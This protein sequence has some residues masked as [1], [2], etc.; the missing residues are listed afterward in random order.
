M[1]GRRSGFERGYRVAYRLGFVP[2]EGY[3]EAAAAQVDA[4]LDREEAERAARPLGRALD[5]G[6]GRGQYTPELARRGWEAVGVDV[7]PASVAAARRRGGDGAHYVVADVT[8]L[9]DAGLGTFD[10]F[11]DVGCFQGLGAGQRSAEGRGVTASARP[12]ATVLL[13]AFGPTWYR[14]LVGGVSPGEV[15]SAFPGWDVTS[16]EDA[17]T[18][19]L[20]WPMNRTAPRW[21]RLQRAAP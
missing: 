10:L 4:L 12:G 7:V 3:R 15:E 16:T 20:G 13:L 17:D 2:W 5:L 6:C 21:Y 14:R 11:L 19:G 9:E 1:A 8:A 18:T